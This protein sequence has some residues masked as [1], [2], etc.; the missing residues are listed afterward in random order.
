[1]VRAVL[2]EVVLVLE[3]EEVVVA[4]RTTAASRTNSGEFSQQSPGILRV[5]AQQKVVKAVSHAQ[6]YARPS[7][8][9]VS[10][11]S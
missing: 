6:T 2:D 1:M 3:V 9:A 11:V 8:S 5:V 4:L 7:E 10:V